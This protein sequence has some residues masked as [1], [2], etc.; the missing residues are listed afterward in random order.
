ML[1]KEKI[2]TVLYSQLL[3]SYTVFAPL[4]LLQ[5]HYKEHLS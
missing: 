3:K 2:N 4:N 5:F 1:Q